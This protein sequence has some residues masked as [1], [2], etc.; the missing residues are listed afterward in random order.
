MMYLQSQME[1]LLSQIHEDFPNT[2]DFTRLES[3]DLKITLLY[4][5]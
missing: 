3:F 1:D 5:N 2:I 4:S